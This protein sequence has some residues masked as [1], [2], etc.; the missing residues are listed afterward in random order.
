MSKD[1]LP[2]SEPARFQGEVEP[3]C[4]MSGVTCERPIVLM[5][6]VVEAH[7]LGAV[8]KCRMCQQSGGMQPL[9][10][11]RGLILEQPG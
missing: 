7:D 11:D 6:H 10:Q 8:P 9:K 3:L 4:G 5:L 1:S 2:S